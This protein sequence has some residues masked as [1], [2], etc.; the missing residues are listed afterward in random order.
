MF[1]GALPILGFIGLLV[2]IVV[3]HEAG[4]FFMAKLFKVKVLEFGIGFPPRLASITRGG[5]RYSINLIPLG[6]FCKMLGE[7]D[8]SHSGSLAGKSPGVR[9][10]ILAAGPFMNL[11]LTV[12]LFSLLFLIPQDVP[13]GDV[14]VTD[15]IADSPASKGGVLAGDIILEAN[16]QT[17]KTDLDLRYQI[18]LSDGEEMTWLI[19]RAGND[20]IVK[21]IPRIK[22]PEGEGA[23]G[24][25][26]VTQN[27]ELEER[28]VGIPRALFLGVSQTG[29]VLVL[30][31][32]EIGNWLSAGRAP[33]VAGPV[34]MAQ[35]FGEV[36]QAEGISLKNRILTTISLAALISLSLSIFNFLP[37][38]ALDGGRILF[39]GIEWIRR[40]KRIP[41]QKEGL[42]HLFGFALL[43]T[44]A[45][46]ITVE[47]IGRVL[48]GES[49]FGG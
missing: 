33:E 27:I 14:S 38:P 6:G 41:P 45:I 19:R 31:K 17:L 11:I 22:P 10:L 30:A 16:G 15:V 44:L 37:I 35:V 26:V 46:L 28:S 39:V 25:R 43:I 29:Q 18:A 40:G 32:N 7:E 24:I 13:V 2:S 12:A 8:P 3:I 1:S 47:D 48:R 20:L 36:A 5:T 42:V 21:V 9:F 49:F 4:H 23:T 34:G